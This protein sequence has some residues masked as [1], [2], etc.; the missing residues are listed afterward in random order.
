MK[1]RAA[2]IFTW[3]IIVLLISPILFFVMNGSAE[4]YPKSSFIHFRKPMFSR[5]WE[6]RGV[7]K[8]ECAR[9]QWSFV[10]IAEYTPS[11]LLQY[12]EDRWRRK[13]NPGSPLLANSDYQGR[14]FP[15]FSFVTS[16]FEISREKY[17]GYNTE[18]ITPLEYEI[19]NY[20]FVYKLDDWYE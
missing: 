12:Y 5:F 18:N 2:H 16:N 20:L 4:I 1:S 8:R 13:P 3:V 11:E 9:I 17:I 19:G 6:Q 10:A 7:H 14:F 15:I